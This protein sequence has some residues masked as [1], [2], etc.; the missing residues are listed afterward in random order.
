LAVGEGGMVGGKSQRALFGGGESVDTVVVETRRVF[1]LRSEHQSEERGRDFVVLRVRFRDVQ[2]NR[3]ANHLLGKILVGI[4]RAAGKMPLRSSDQHF[5]RRPR[6]SIGQRKSLAEAG[7]GLHDRH[8]R[9]PL[10]QTVRG[11]AGKKAFVRA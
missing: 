3:I 5:D 1:A 7:H 10:F 8:V 2:C 6:H 9:S 11:G 4:G